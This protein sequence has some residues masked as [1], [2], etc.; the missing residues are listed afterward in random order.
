ML[1][2]KWNAFIH[3]VR[4]T[5]RFV[6]KG[7]QLALC[8]AL[9]SNQFRTNVSNRTRNCPT[10]KRSRMINSGRMPLLG[11]VPNFSIT[12]ELQSRP[13]NLVHVY[14]SSL[15]IFLRIIAKLNGMLLHW[16]MSFRY[17]LATPFPLSTLRYS[18]MF[19]QTWKKHCSRTF[20]KPKTFSKPAVIAS[21]AFANK[22]EGCYCTLCCRV[23]S[24]MNA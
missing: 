18:S 7:L 3:S 4:C 21:L 5:V 22:I 2:A 23:A 8:G 12:T 6:A 19:F 15:S 9:V 10:S 14:L 11:T 17:D 13:Q 24:K 16:N 20:G 1:T